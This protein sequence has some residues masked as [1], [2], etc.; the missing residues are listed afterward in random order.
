MLKKFFKQ[1][2]DI[3][4]GPILPK[5][6]SLT[7]PLM[8]TAILNSTLNLIDMFWVGKLGSDSIA[9]VAIG[10][11]IMMVV[12]ATLIGITR[13]TIA[14]VAR[15]VGAKDAKN[16][17][18]VASQSIMLGLII[19]L[20]TILVGL[21]FTDKL[22]L[23]LGASPEVLKIGSSYLKIILIGGITMVLL[24][25][26]NSI[27]Q[28][29]GDTVT[30]MKFMFLS[31]IINIILDPIFIFGL[32]VPRMNTSGAALAT[33][34]SQAVPAF[35]VLLLLS[36]RRSKVHI[37]ISQFKI[38][39]TFL[40]EMLKI[41]LPASLQM[42]FRSIMG[43][44]LMGIVASFGT[45]AIAAYGIGMRL[46][47]LVLM[48]A[49]AFGGAAATLAGQNLGA[50]Q[51]KRAQRSAWTATT[52][53]MFLMILVAI[54]FFIFAPQ[55]VGFFIKDKNVISIGTQFLRITA[56]FY[57]FIPLGVV[58]GQSLAGAG[59]TITP[60]FITLLSLWGFQIPMA[61]YLSQ[62]TMWGINGIWWTNAFA[63]VLH[64]L[65]IMGWFTTGR[66][67]KRIISSIV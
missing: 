32:G 30:P 5:M 2:K 62:A 52:L 25:F 39:L 67:K 13:G 6:L 19:A 4:T 41:G 3:T 44:V 31:N 43:L 22:F 53:D 45:A 33:V 63:S 49:F 18:A 51:P 20:A 8:V 48:P 17:D 60:M 16:A 42:F 14:L 34:L 23:I 54:L 24:S 15:Y 21:L 27:L 40:K 9:A 28:A 50:K 38:K 26:G 47:M 7:G 59:D 35:L 10:G 65:L 57:L 56:P 58:L 29:E 64:G 36:K 12:F 1:D 55:I 46:Q 37:H 66:W 61:I 11:T